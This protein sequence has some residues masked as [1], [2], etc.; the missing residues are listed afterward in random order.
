MKQHT[1]ALPPG[2]IRVATSWVGTS[3]PPLA[4]LTALSFGTFLESLYGL[5]GRESWPHSLH[6]PKWAERSML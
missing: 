6:C 3:L 1:I 5:H 2:S 4:S